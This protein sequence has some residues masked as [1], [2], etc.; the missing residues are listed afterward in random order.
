MPHVHG[1]V[2]LMTQSAAGVSVQGA[3]EASVRGQLTSRLSNATGLVYGQWQHSASLRRQGG[4]WESSLSHL[5]AAATCLNTPILSFTERT[6]SNAEA[7]MQP[8]CINQWKK[9]PAQELLTLFRCLSKESRSLKS[10][11]LKTSYYLYSTAAHS[12]T[13]DK[14][15]RCRKRRRAPI[16]LL[17][18]GSAY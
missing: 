2:P 16:T 6:T 11:L 18:P 7:G 13:Q 3:A 5:P 10:N 8:Y 17:W 1:P 12:E 14:K 15:L 4:G 9:H